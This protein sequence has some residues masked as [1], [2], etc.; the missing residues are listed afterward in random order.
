[1]GI[2]P[3]LASNNLEN[4]LVDWILYLD[5]N[6]LYSL[7]NL[8]ANPENEACKALIHLIKENKK[9]IKIVL[10]YS[11]LTKKEL[12]AKKDDSNY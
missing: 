9:H 3:K 12:N 6:V 5:T 2:D 10:R 8:H 4:S 7:L 1:L 11:E